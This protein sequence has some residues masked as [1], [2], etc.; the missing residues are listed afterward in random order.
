M[1]ANGQPVKKGQAI[2]LLC[3]ARALIFESFD[4]RRVK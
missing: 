2:L 1:R 4:D 3:H